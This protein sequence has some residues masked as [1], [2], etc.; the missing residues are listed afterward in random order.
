MD[1]WD[2]VV[3]TPFC[4][5]YLTAFALRCMSSPSHVPKAKCNFAYLI[6]KYISQNESW[7]H[8]YQNNSS[9]VLIGP[10]YKKISKKFFLIVKCTCMNPA[11]IICDYDLLIL[12]GIILVQIEFN[13]VL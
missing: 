6:S 8:N 2:D 3:Y 4:N 13:D 5:S 10:P 1:A 9:W 7:G 11:S 12:I